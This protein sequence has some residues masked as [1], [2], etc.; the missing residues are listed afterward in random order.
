MN[1]VTLIS[2]AGGVGKTTVTAN[3]AVALA[4]R[5]KKVL[6]VDI[7]PQN[8]QRIHL[9]LDPGQD[10]GLAREGIT[11]KAIFD[12]PFGGT[13]GDADSGQVHFIPFGRVS[14]DELAEF[15]RDLSIRP[16]W[17]RN[18]LRSLEPIGFD[19]VLIDTPQ[20]PSVFLGQALT[21]ANLALI[22]LQPDAASYLS[23]PKLE[24][25]IRDHAQRE[26]DFLGA[27]KLINQMPANSR[28]SHQVRAALYANNAEGTVPLSIHHDTSVAQALAH[29]RPALEFRPGAMASLDYQ[30]LAD[31]LVGTLAYA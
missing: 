21:A 11:L 14:D 1:I 29:E 3:L 16:R 8:S 20:P 17:L 19:C 5:R 18:H 9:G 2:A 30:Y 26:Q 4:Q 12:S 13:D 24:V 15:R 10:A 22:V 23:L 7:D 28:L 31:W 27:Y 6:V 25:M